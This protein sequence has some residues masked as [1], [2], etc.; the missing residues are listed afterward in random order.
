ML[1][2]GSSATDGKVYPHYE[3]VNDTVWLTSH[4]GGLGITKRPVASLEMH[5]GFSTTMNVVG[6]WYLR[7]ERVED[8]PKTG[9]MVVRYWLYPGEREFG[10]GPPDV[11]KIVR[12][13]NSGG[14]LIH[15]EWVREN[16]DWDYMWPDVHAYRA[17]PDSIALARH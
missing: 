14:T 6:Y 15:E 13:D 7:S 8:D 17:I 4:F 1:A 2:C 10:K 16:S 11:V 3:V 9:S 5:K 12:L